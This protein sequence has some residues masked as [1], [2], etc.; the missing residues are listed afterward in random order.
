MNLIYSV[1][2]EDFIDMEIL[3]ATH[4]EVLFMRK[5]DFPT[6]MLGK[7][8]DSTGGERGRGTLIICS[9][10][11]GGG[12]AEINFCSVGSNV[13]LSHILLISQHPLPVNIA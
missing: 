12:G 4:H 8:G 3:L 10:G 5:E 11:E 13:I 2:I 9:V 1:N 6:C 7:L